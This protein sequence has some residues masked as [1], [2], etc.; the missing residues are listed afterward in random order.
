M[1]YYL[2]QLKN[3]LVIPESYCEW[4]YYR[5]KVTEF[6]LTNQ[7]K[8]SIVILGAGPSNDIDLKKLSLHYEEIY[9]V[10]N[11]TEVMQEAVKNYDLEGNKK[12]KLITCDFWEFPPM[13]LEGLEECLQQK[14]EMSFLCQYVEEMQ[15]WAYRNTAYPMIDADAEVVVIGIHSQFNSGIEALLYYYK[16]HYKIDENGVLAV[17]RKWNKIAIEK[18]HEYLFGHFS[19]ICLG[20]EYSSYKN[21]EEYRKLCEIAS[22]FAKG[23]GQI[24]RNIVVSRVDGAY[25]AEQDLSK[26][27]GQRKVAISALQY[28]FWNFSKLKGYLMC[29][30]YVIKTDAS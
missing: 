17:L 24:A 8:K 10:D 16:E 3:G 27:I 19:S 18:F 13:A 1:G 5:N 14:E 12:I 7:K 30:Y 28:E 23:Q 15:Q 11:R 4:E 26:R 2:Q 21:E 20:Y 29:L 22:L 25:E 9:L 6:I